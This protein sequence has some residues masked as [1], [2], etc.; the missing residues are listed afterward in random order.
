M[1]SFSP[2][3]DCSN[4]PEECED[5]CPDNFSKDDPGA[6]GCAILLHDELYGD[7]DEDGV[8]DCMDNCID[9]SISCMQQRR[10]SIRGI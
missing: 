9:V 1:C 2:N 3:H 7:K 5:L 6:C 8:V 4:F 10:Q